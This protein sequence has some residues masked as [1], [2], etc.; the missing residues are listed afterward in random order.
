MENKKNTAGL[1]ATEGVGIT[2]TAQELLDEV[3]YTASE[4]A[5][6]NLSKCAR[7]QK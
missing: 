3:E 7:R 4:K 1:T 6:L 2:E 5:E